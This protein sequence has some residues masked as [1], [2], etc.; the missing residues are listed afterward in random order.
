M[1]KKLDFQL[2]A[3]VENT[4]DAI[5]IKDRDG[6]YLFVNSVGAELLGRNV[7]EIL[8]KQDCDFLDCGESALVMKTDQ[9]VMS[10]REPCSCEQTVQLG[11][12]EHSFLTQNYPYC[13]ER[14]DV[15]GQIGVSRDITSYKEAKKSLERANA[16]LQAALDSTAEG[17]LGIDEHGYITYYNKRYLEMWRVPEAIL[18]AQSDDT[19]MQHVLKQLKEPQR[20]HEQ[21]RDVYS[22][23][24]GEFND[25]FE[26][27]DGR[28][29]E[30]AS[31]LQRIGETVIGRVW[32]FRDITARYR[33]E[34]TLQDANR[35]L[36]TRVAERT[37]ALE[38]ANRKLTQLN[39]QLLY[40]TLHDSLTG[41]ANRTLFTNH[42]RQ[43][44]E[45]YKS[46][47][48]YGFSVLFL[49]FDR[50]KIVNDSLGHTVGDKLLVQIAERLLRSVRPE[51][52]VA[53]L[54]GDEFVILLDNVLGVEDSIRTA[55]RVQCV[56]SKPFAFDEQV[57][58]ISASI[59]ITTSTYNYKRPEDV[60]RDADIA[61]Y[62]AKALSKATYQVF[63]REMRIRVESLSTLENDMRRAIERRELEVHYQPIVAVPN[64]GMIGVEALL[65][66]KHP[67]LGMVSRAEFMPVAEETGLVV[68]FDHWILHEACKQVCEWQDVSPLSLNVNLSG[69]TFAHPSLVESVENSLRT[70]GC[71]PRS[72]KLELTESVLVHSSE[73]TLATFS[74]LKALGV[75]LYID[76][77]GTGYSS[78]AYL[79][80]LPID[81]IKIDGTFIQGLT[82]SLESVALVKT[83]LEM[84]HSLDIQVVAEGVETKQ[85]F[86]HLRR[87][88]CPYAQGYLFSK[89]LSAEDMTILVDKKGFSG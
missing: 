64:G 80:S 34:E 42:L 35:K 74:R 51:D 54:G 19:L 85:Q 75:Q 77:F 62:R 23:S 11:G 4:S 70:T 26:L 68:E 76:D 63:T 78:L 49:D 9:Q 17:V 24:E 57:I 30:R 28:V 8:G 46:R 60:L 65:R 2:Q 10:T 36:A 61:M 27:F 25:V 38:R 16:F 31:R 52:T 87:L 45:R 86:E 72:L 56:L 40:S 66:W 6:R 44:I 67:K 39:K 5:Y 37:T 84:A 33:V 12:Q 22:D 29:I 59:G 18:A 1:R 48:N 89:P 73:E 71:D 14:G 58:Q 3:M 53:R 32:S 15:I 41:L 13:S 79:Q 81:A 55:E 43:A 69:Q 83:I 47:D 7:E 82:M 21:T 50:F 88:G 20:F